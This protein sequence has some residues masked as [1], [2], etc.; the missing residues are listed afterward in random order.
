MCRLQ[1]GRRYTVVIIGRAAPVI[2]CQVVTQPVPQFAFSARRLRELDCCKKKL[3]RLV[4]LTP[5]D[6]NS[7]YARRFRDPDRTR[8]L[9][10]EWRRVYEF[11]K[12]HQNDMGAVF[13]ELTDQFLALIYDTIFE[14][15]IVGVILFI[16]FGKKSGIDPN[17]YL[18]EIASEPWKSWSTPPKEYKGL[19]GTYRK[20]LLYDKQREAI[21]V[22]GEIQKR[23][24]TT[25]Y[26]DYPWTHF[27]APGTLHVLPQPIPVGRIRRLDRFK[28]FGKCQT[29]C[30]N[31]THEEYRVLTAQPR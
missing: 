12:R 27:F 16:R 24:R 31:V 26:P 30:W 15:D 2:V 11:L 22:E 1:D 8:I 25:Y 18:D 6:S 21:T 13:S 17:T 19:D 14:Q 3:K 29:A 4:L 10:L 9:H 28:F 20:L 23:R 5:D 7:A